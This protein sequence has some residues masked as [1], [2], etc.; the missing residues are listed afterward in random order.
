MGNVARVLA[1]DPVPDTPEP[2][3]HV[4]AVAAV[5]QMLRRA[6]RVGPSSGTEPIDSDTWAA[7]PPVAPDFWN[8]ATRRSRRTADGRS[9]RPRW[10]RRP[11]WAGQVRLVAAMVLI[12]GLAAGWLATSEMGS[13]R[14]RARVAAV[15]PAARAGDARPASPPDRTRD[16]PSGDRAL[17]ALVPAGAICGYG[18]ASAN[19]AHCSIGAVH[20]EYSLLGAGALRA[21]YLVAVG[22]VSHPTTG[23]PACAKGA[24]DERSWSRPT[25]PRVAVGR[26][27]CRVEQGRAAMWWTVDDRGLLAH[28]IATDADL[29]SL[30]AWWESHSER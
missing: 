29:A 1:E 14:P 22:S 18:P 17:R 2:V 9:A 16:V 24:E 25:E 28:A 13:R 23:A 4:D 6:L 10:L 3:P 30:Y 5:D 11:R 19:E 12:V 27:A 15:A 26:Y 21:G 20:V 7:A 8:E